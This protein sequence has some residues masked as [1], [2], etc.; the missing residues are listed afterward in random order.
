VIAPFGAGVGSTMGFLT[1]PLAF[2]F[3]RSSIEEIQALDWTR[4]NALFA[5]MEQEGVALLQ[6]SGLRREEIT[7][8]RSADL[9]Y[10]GQGHEEEVPIPAGALSP[11]A[12]PLL[13]NTFETV[14]R[15]LYGRVAEAV[16]VETVNWRVAVRGP[17]PS[18]DL[19][20]R[21][22]TLTSDARSALK[23]R[24]PVYFPQFGDY[25][26]TSVYD[27]YQLGPGSVFAGPA[28][29]EERESTVVVGPGATASIDEYLNLV[30]GYDHAR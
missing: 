30:M 7:I 28:I 23:G 2:D 24:R 18:L 5:E 10:V 13:I 17:K 4:V 9:R 20:A 25:R 12:V 14:Y 21:A 6:R 8:A 1:A 11:A 26:S 29:V 27:R 22:G 3:V 15:K 16:A 19:R